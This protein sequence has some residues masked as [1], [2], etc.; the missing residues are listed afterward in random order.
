[1]ESVRGVAAGY[2]RSGPH[3]DDPEV[4]I[5]AQREAIAA[6]ARFR[7]LALTES[8]T[9][10]EEPGSV[11]LEAR[12]GGS[13]LVSWLAQPHPGGVAVLAVRL[14]RL[15]A[16]ATECL[17]HLDRW[18]ERGTTLHLL[19]LGGAPL[20]FASPAAALVRAS[21]SAARAM[22]LEQH[23]R[24][25]L[26]SL[27]KRKR[28][29]KPLLGEKVVRGFIVPDPVELHAVERIRELADEGKS[30]RLIAEALD[31]E[32]VPTK[33]RARSWSKEAIR[34]ILQRVERGELRSLRPDDKGGAD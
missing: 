7:G 11:P 34:L 24:P 10:E 25:S 1:M 33:R 4:S 3:D 2:A 27:H 12:P 8:F 9:D 32:G 15:F 14:E 13:A 29:V 18:E 28:G 17:A 23:E 19:D 6:Y 16:S 26:R 21:L 5:E 30:L 20:D 22:E 31:Q